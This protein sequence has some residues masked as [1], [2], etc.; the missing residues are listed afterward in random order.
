VLAHGDWRLGP[1]DLAVHHGERVLLS[2]PNGSGKSTVLAT[3]A[4]RSKPI[5]GVR[6]IAPGAVVAQLGQARD[7]LA[8]DGTIVAGVRALTGLGEAD[9]RT[10]LASYGLEAD[11][12]TRPARSL[13]PG[14]RTRAELAVIAH[15]RATC[16]LL[17]EPTNHLD[18]AALE[19]LEAALDDW[20]GALV[21]ATHDHRL[22]DALRVDRELVLGG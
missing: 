10:A 2:G 6:R 17:D 1:V 14:E 20:P 8:G 7:L 19:V 22:R 9:A 3:L 21:V 13:S 15:R 12:A 11:A 5:A 4:G 18:V 16:L